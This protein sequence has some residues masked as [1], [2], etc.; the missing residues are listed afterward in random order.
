MVAPVGAPVDA[1]VEAAVDAAVEAIVD[2]AVDAPVLA[3][4]KEKREGCVM[5]CSW[6]LSTPCV[7]GAR[8]DSGAG[9]YGGGL[10][11]C[12]QHHKTTTGEIVTD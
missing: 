4:R 6:L 1:A 2:A 10:G 12:L 3:L 11:H 5:Q 8:A 9:G 7:P